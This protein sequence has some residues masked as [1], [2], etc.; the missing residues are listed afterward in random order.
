MTYLCPLY[1]VTKMGVD[2]SQISHIDIDPV[3]AGNRY[4]CWTG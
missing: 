2:A 4:R 1:G 3:D